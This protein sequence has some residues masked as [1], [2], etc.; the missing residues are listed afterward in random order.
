MSHDN[1][2]AAILSLLADRAPEATICPSEAARSLAHA[3]GRGNDWRDE[4]PAVH[5]AARALAREGK[6][7]LTQR[8]QPVGEPEG[9]YRIAHGTV[10]QKETA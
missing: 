5:D 3:R 9:A 2:R 1:T 10:G 4:M 7:V 6:V 8:G